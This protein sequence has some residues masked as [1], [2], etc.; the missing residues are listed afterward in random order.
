MDAARED[1]QIVDGREEDVE[2]GERWRRIIHCGD[3]QKK[4]VK[5]KGIRRPRSHVIVCTV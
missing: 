4:I 1:M 5:L 3:S 2:H